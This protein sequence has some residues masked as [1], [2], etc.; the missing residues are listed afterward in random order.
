MRRRLA[1]LEARI[2]A[3]EARLSELGDALGDPA[4]YRDGGQVRAVTAERKE[5]EAEIAWRLREWEAL[6]ERLGGA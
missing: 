2:H 6:A 3:L 5:A 4:L 1:A